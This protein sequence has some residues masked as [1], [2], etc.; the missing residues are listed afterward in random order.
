[1]H[2]KNTSF[3]ALGDEANLESCD[4]GRRF[5]GRR[6][7]SAG[8]PGVPRGN[9][10][11]NRL[12]GADRD[13]CRLA[14][15]SLTAVNSAPGA[16]HDTAA[17]D[18]SGAPRNGVLGKLMGAGCRP[19]LPLSIQC[20]AGAIRNM[21]TSTQ[22]ESTICTQTGNKSKQTQKA[23]RRDRQNCAGDRLELAMI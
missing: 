22:P 4:P 7:R 15:S 3:T 17:P 18:R 14:I 13:P 1:M 16:R 23:R 11:R 5:P 20:G 19:R 2:M 9:Y 21:A 12:G 8:L 10:P 6:L